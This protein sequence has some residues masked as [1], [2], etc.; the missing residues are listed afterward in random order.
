M[1]L[2]DEQPEPVHLRH[3][4]QHSAFLRLRPG[5]L[6]DLPPRGRDQRL[7]AGLE[8]R[9]PDGRDF[10]GQ[11]PPD[12]QVRLHGPPCREV[13]LL[14][15]HL[16]F[17]DL[18]CLRRLQVRRGAGRAQQQRRRDAPRMAAV[19]RRFGRYSCHGGW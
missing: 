19:R 3:R 16:D 8:R 18:L 15:E 7:D 13:H 1:D 4:E 5:R 9:E 2:H 14:R 6:D 12:V 17:H 10:Q 11:R